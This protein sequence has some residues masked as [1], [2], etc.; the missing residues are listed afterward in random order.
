M[1]MAQGIMGIVGAGLHIGGTAMEASAA[2][3]K[4]DQYRDM[5]DDW[6]PDIPAYQKGYFEDLLKYEEDAGKL[7]D[8]IGKRDM[9]SALARREMAMPGIGGYLK[10]A[11]SAAGPMAG[12][13]MPRWLQ[14]VFRSS[15]GTNAVGLGFGGSPFGAGLTGWGAV[16]RAMGA[17]RQGVGLLGALMGMMPNTRSPSGMDILSEGVMNPAQRTQTQLNVRNQNIGMANY[18]MGMNNSDEVWAGSMKDAGAT[19]IGGSMGGGGG[20]S[21]GGLTEGGGGGWGGWGGGGGGGTAGYLGSSGGAEYYN[22]P[23]NIY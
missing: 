9:T 3:E 12:G 21:M 5:M 23:T 14:D 20:G 15:A 19:L 4:R 8:S 1:G 10:G 2:D 22:V 6:L 17:Q 16:D 18:L 7:A 13:E 11:L